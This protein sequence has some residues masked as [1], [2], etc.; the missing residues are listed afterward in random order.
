MHESALAVATLVTLVTGVAGAQEKV[1][2][3]HSWSDYIDPQV[4]EDFSAKGGIQVVYDL[5]DSNEL[6]K[7]GMMAKISNFVTYPNA[8]PASY[9]MIDGEVKIDPAPFPHLR[10]QGE[11]V[12][13][14]TFRPEGP[15]Y[16]D[17]AVDQASHR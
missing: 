10:G 7:P 13:G 16:L 8:A 3:V 2:K 15:A 9:A 6:R 11:A 12:H 14:H 1:V 4:L 5:F 17:K